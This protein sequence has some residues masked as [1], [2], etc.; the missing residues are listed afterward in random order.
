MGKYFEH[1]EDREWY[2]IDYQL[3]DF[4]KNADG[5][6]L[7]STGA[8]ADPGEDA[9]DVIDMSAIEV[10]VIDHALGMARF[11]E[12]SKKLYITI[13]DASRVVHTARVKIQS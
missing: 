13:D 12:L 8:Q 3:V 1:H 9:G 5:F 4:A 7:S 10:D 2:E 6:L 11:S